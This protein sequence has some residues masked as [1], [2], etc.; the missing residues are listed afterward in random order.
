MGPWGSSDRQPSGIC[1]LQTSKRYCLKIN[2]SNMDG[3]WRW[4]PKVDMH[5]AVKRPE[6]K[7]DCKFKPSLGC[8]ISS[9]QPRQKHETLKTS[10][11]H[12][13]Y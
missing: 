2:N 12:Q 5:P 8:I 4:T 6:Q 11:H 13:N 9:K 1:E 3:T 7:D 10:C